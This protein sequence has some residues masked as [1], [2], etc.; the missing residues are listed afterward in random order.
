M[1]G[2]LVAFASAAALLAVLWSAASG[3]GPAETVP[4]CAALLAILALMAAAA[5]GAA[6]LCGG[7]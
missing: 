4:L 3:D 1:T 6:A 5:S 2:A 7:W